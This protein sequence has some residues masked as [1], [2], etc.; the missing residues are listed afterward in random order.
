MPYIFNF[1]LLGV[2]NEYYLAPDEDRR[3]SGGVNVFNPLGPQEGWL[4]LR[5][6][7]IYLGRTILNIFILNIEKDLSRKKFAFL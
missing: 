4:A 5:S 2:G 7:E 6:S 1:F 3:V